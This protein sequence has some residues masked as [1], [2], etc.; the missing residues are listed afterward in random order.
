[1][2]YGELNL[3]TVYT[4][5]DLRNGR[6]LPGCVPYNKGK[7]WSDFMP[8]RSQRRSAKGWKNLEL[9]RHRPPNAGRARKLVIAITDGGGWT[10]LPSVKS[11]GEFCG[12]NSENVGRCCRLNALHEANTNHRYM[13][14]RFYFESDDIWINKIN[15]HG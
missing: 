15:S 1:M 9:Y 4:G 6:F 10:I 2:S 13:G 12:G 8:K 3:G 7:K 14:Y 11:A 5:R